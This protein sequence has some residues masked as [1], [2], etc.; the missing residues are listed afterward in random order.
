[1]YSEIEISVCTVMSKTEFQSLTML[2]STH[3]LFLMGYSLKKWHLQRM[4][5]QT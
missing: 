2:V 1:M 3:K 4:L 5:L